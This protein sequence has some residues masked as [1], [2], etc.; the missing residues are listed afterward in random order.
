MPK[1]TSARSTNLRGEGSVLIGIFGFTIAFAF[2]ALIIFLLKIGYNKVSKQFATETK[3]EEIKNIVKVVYHTPVKYTFFIKEDNFI[4]AKWL[5][6]TTASIDA[7][8]LIEDV[9]K[10][11]YMYVEYDIN[12]GFYSKI[13]I[14]IHSLKNTNICENECGKNCTEQSLSIAE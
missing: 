13:N 1:C 14:H 4:E 11:E 6:F 7:I 5:Y 8:K 10:E 3:H 9:P 2:I 12:G